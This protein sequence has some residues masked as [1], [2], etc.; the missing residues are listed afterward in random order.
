[1]GVGRSPKSRPAHVAH[2]AVDALESG[3]A[4]VSTGVVAKSMIAISR[5]LPQPARTAFHGWF[6]APGKR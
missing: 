3:Q 4:E 5:V 1:M 2:L 6:Y